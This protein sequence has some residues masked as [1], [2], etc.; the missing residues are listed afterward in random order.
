[1]A[2]RWQGCFLPEFPAGLTSAPPALAAVADESNV[3][4]LL[5]RQEIFH[6]LGFPGGCQLVENPLA[7]HETLV[8]FL[9]QKDP[10]EK[11]EGTHSSILG[12]PWWLS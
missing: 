6:F 10:L 3:L 9:D 5:I 2:A 7:M 8:R 12:V 4:S 11:G 1:M